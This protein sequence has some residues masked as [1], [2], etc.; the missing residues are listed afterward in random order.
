MNTTIIIVLGALILIVVIAIVVILIKGK[1]PDEVDGSDT[2]GESF[3]EE[4]LKPPK[5]FSNGKEIATPQLHKKG[6]SSPSSATNTPVMDNLATPQE[7][8]SA[9][10]PPVSNPVEGIEE[11]APKITNTLNTP[12]ESSSPNTVNLGQDMYKSNPLPDNS[13]INSDLE[14]LQKSSQNPTATYS[15]TPAPQETPTTEPIEAPPTEPTGGKELDD[16]TNDINNVLTAEGSST[17]A[18]SNP[19]Q[20]PTATQDPLENKMP[21]AQP[22]NNQVNTPPVSQPGVVSQNSTDETVESSI[23]PAPPIT[24][25]D[26]T[27]KPEEGGTVPV[28]PPVQPPQPTTV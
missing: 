18:I 3:Q 24:P 26:I 5:A 11:T 17:S 21:Q 1:D 15:N 10:T 6:N 4:S 28:N 20:T 19:V 9:Q 7:T 22:V 14:N 27:P 25:D 16:I 23:P 2:Q 12:A 13:K 8:L